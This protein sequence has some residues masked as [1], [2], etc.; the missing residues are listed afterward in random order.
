MGRALICVDLSPSICSIAI[1]TLFP[2]LVYGVESAIHLVDGAKF[3]LLP[4]VSH[5][6]V[7]YNRED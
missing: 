6:L 2:I 7:L 1:I 3:P 4:R 5:S